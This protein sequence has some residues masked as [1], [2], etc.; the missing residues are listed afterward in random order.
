MLPSMD[1]DERDDLWLRM[2]KSPEEVG[3]FIRTHGGEG[4]ATVAKLWG[5]TKAAIYELYQEEAD[6]HDEELRERSGWTTDD[7]D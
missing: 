5:K 2:F 4:I 7:D 3:E 6:A 1:D